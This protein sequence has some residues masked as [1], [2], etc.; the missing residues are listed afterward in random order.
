MERYGDM[1]MFTDVVFD[2]NLSVHYLILH[3]SQKVIEPP[4]DVSCG[5]RLCFDLP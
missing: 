4:A 3:C 1:A 5:F 2:I